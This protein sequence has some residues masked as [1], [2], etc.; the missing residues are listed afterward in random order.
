MCRRSSG[1]S[2][3]SRKR[4]DTACQTGFRR[5]G[6]GLA[7]IRRGCLAVT[8]PLSR[9]QFPRNWRLSGIDA[10]TVQ[11]PTDPGS[12]GTATGTVMAVVQGGRSMRYV[13]LVIHDHAKWVV[14]FPDFPDLAATGFLLEE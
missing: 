6:S 9:E 2:S 10:I 4:S 3:V 7:G 14:L 8:A 12:A 1:C 5:S 13:V 11:E